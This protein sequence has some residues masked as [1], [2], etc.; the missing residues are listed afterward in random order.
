LFI[1]G[2]TVN[3]D[4]KGR[5]AFPT[6][7]RAELMERCD[8]QVVLT[9]DE[10]RCLSLYPRPDWDELQRSL[11]RMPNHDGRV[12]NL[13][14]I[15]LGHATELELDKSGRVLIP[16]RLRDFASLDKR[17]E[18]TGLGNKFEIWNEEAW[19]KLCGDWVAEGDSSGELPDPL[20]D[21]K[22]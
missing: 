7:Y 2:S 12:R 4:A 1:G 11:V 9:V 8:G 10:K 18:L 17:V 13:Q 6:R 14:R 15:L 5:L 22:R 20:S 16:Q 3:L 21:L 19:K